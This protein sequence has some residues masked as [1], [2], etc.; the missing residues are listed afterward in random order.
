MPKKFLAPL[1]VVALLYL[2]GCSNAE[3]KACDAA[4]K[5]VS[6]YEMSYNPK[7]VMAERLESKKEVFTRER[8]WERIEAERQGIKL[9][10]NNAGLE[11]SKLRK[12]AQNEYFK[13]QLVIVN[14][15]SCF[16]PEQVVEAQIA[17]YND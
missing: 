5:A 13:S 9:P 2:P 17:T 16:T 8:I 11:S 10:E 12:E 7:F 6:E 14:N 1:V 3:A 4:K 15:P